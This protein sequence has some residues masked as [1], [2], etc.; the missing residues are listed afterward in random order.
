MTTST[1]VVRL[2]IV[3]ASAVVAA[4]VLAGCSSSPSSSAP[5]TAATTAAAPGSFGNIDVQL[6]WIKNSEFA[7]EYYALDN[8]YYTQAGFGTVTLTSGPSI[9]TSELASGKAQFALSD[10]ASVAAYDSDPANASDPIV[11]VGATY[12]KNPFTIASLGTSGLTTPKSLVG[13]KIGVDASNTSL[14]NGFLAANGIDPTQVTVVPGSFNG[15]SM[16]ESGKADGYVSYITNEAIAIKKD[17]GSVTQLD[18]A[19]NNFAYPAETIAVTKSFLTAHPDEVKAFLTA[20]IKGWSDTFKAS[21]TD[22]VSKVIEHFNA[23][24]SA[25]GSAEKQNSSGKLDPTETKAEFDGQKA[26]VA[27][28]ETKA[29]GLFTISSSLQT[30]TVASMAKAGFAVTA[31]Q[32]FDTSLLTQIYTENPGLMNYGG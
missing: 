12:Q 5:S 24:V 4:G 32:I 17:T 23:A 16:V 3:T 19:D 6:S 15:P 18:F 14:F 28:A 27:D 13:K 20:E 21:D 7:G 10:A 30:E 8:G 11:I 22:V 26:L 25:P 31:D 9:G 1:R 29:N 2:A